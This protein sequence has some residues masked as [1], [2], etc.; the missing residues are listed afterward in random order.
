MISCATRILESKL[1]KYFQSPDILDPEAL[2]D[3][4]KPVKVNS[5]TFFENA[6]SMTR[7]EVDREWSALGKPVDRDRWY[8]TLRPPKLHA[9]K[10]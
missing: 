1:T 4:Y 2:H 8:R 9:L 7:L 5:S 10:P 3:Y 6:V